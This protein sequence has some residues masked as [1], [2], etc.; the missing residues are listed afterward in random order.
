VVSIFDFNF[1]VEVGGPTIFLELRTFFAFFEI[2]TLYLWSSFSVAS[3]NDLTIFSES[4]QKKFAR[5]SGGLE[6]R[7]AHAMC[8]MTL[9]NGF[10]HLLSPLRIYDAYFF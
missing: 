4:T 2:V 7:L 6:I 8:A 9:S 10:L 3:Y 5:G 1:N